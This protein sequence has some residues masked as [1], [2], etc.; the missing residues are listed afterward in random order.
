MKRFLALLLA[1]VMLFALAAC[2]TTPP[3][4]ENEIVEEE[5]L[6]TEENEDVVPEDETP[7]E[8]EKK[9]EETPVTKPAQKPAEKPTEKPAEKPTEKPAEKPV[10]TPAEKPAETIGDALLS[11]FRANKDKSAEE[12]ANA[13]LTSPVIKFMGGTAPME[14]GYLA[15]FNN[16]ITGFTSC[17]MFAPNIGTIPFV[18]YVFEVSGDASAFAEKLK[19]EA[20]PRWNICTEAEQTICEVSGNKIFFLMCPRAMEE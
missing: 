15:G 1:L 2:K 18:G 8:E 6:P 10:E 12:I 13:C 17:T 5:N 19:A 9:P 4:E 11:V 16:E 14:E 3:V 7:S 20:N